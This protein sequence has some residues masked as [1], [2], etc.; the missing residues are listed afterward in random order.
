MSYF[1]LI[2][3]TFALLAAVLSATMYNIFIKKEPSPTVKVKGGEMR[4]IIMKSRGGR[5]FYGYL[6]IPFALPATGSLRFQ[7]DIVIIIFC[8]IV[9]LLFMFIQLTNFVIVSSAISGV[10]RSVGRFI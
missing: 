3:L 4:G 1:K 7:V 5:D 6:G 10:G 2:R 8:H 9:Q